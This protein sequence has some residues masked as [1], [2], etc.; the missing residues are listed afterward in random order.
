MDRVDD[1]GGGGALG[2]FACAVGWLVGAIDDGYGYFG[3]LVDVHDGIGGPGAAGYVVFG[4]EDLFE[5]GPA[6]GLDHTP[7]DLVLYTVEVDDLAGVDDGPHFFEGG[8]AGGF[9]DGYVGG[10]GAIGAGI[11]VAGE[12]D[13]DAGGVGRRRLRVYWFCGG[14]EALQAVE[15][16]F[17]AGVVEVLEAEFD[18]VDAGVFGE[19]IDK[20]FDGVNVGIGAQAAQGGGA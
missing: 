10:D 19:F 12:G 14:E 16:F 1:S 20:G 11:L 9:V 18:G 17:G 13:A 5:E 15:N 6:G 7:F 2:G 3:G 4:E 8:G